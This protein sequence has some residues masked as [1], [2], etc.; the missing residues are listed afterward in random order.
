MVTKT[1][2]YIFLIISTS[3]LAQSGDF[4][5]NYFIFPSEMDKY[6]FRQMTF[7]T[8]SKLPED[9]IEETNTLIY[10]P[11]L[12]HR[13]K[14]GLPSNIQI[15]GGFNTNIISNHAALGARWIWKN[16]YFSMSL[17]NDFAF[18]LGLL[19][20]YS[21]ASRIY[22]VNDYPSIAIG[23]KFDGFSVTLKGEASLSVS[24]IKYSDNIRVEVEKNFLNSL[25]VGLFIEQPL[26]RDNVVLLGFKG[27]FARFYYPVWLAFPTFARFNF[28][29]EAVMGIAF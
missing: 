5:R 4:A 14:L 9:F 13:G 16:K 22:G 8:L 1:I 17:G 25:S 3:T 19:D 23:R 11:I 20:G 24:L 2:F 28:I 29:S 26:W 15:Y 21:F 18:W 7:I 12:S 10:L 27:R 6:E